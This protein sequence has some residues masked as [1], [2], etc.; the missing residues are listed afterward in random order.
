MY[1]NRLLKTKP[2]QNTLTLQPYIHIHATY[3][4][5]FLPINISTQTL[6]LV[7]ASNCGK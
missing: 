3:Y 7:I 6:S 5:N 4:M 1:H 2:D